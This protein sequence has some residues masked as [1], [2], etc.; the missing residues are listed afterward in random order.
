MMLELHDVHTYYGESYILQGVSLQVAE[1]EVVT[2]LGRNGVGKTTTIRTV[3][4]FT[5]PR[6]G[7]IVFD[8]KQIA[9]LKAPVISR[10]GIGLVPQGRRIFPNLTVQENLTVASRHAAKG[11][12]NLGEVYRYFPRLQER[13]TN[14]GNQLSGGEQQM[15]AIGRALMTNPRL[16]LLDEPSEGLAPFIVTEIAEIIRQLSQ[17]GLAILLVEQNIKM[18]LKI[19][20]RAYVMNKGKIVWE[21]NSAELWENEEV[22]HQY[23][24]V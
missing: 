2:L 11:G 6:K 7:K 10:L 24:G 4:G 21:G 8:K 12:W 3:I 18:A 5:P 1:G 14:M 9:R 22:K 15:L 20:Q 23:L 17:K 13:Q 19:A 16:L